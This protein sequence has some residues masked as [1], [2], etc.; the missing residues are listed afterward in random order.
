[1]PVEAVR[2]FEQEFLAFVSKSYAEVEHNVRT[3][4]ELS[5]GDGKRLHEALKQFKA[6][7]RT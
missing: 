2:K 5:D 1:V 7:F 3:T 6:T 4:K